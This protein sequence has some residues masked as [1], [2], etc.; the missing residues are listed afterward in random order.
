MK[1]VFLSLVFIFIF[2]FPFFVDALQVDKEISEL[3]SMDDSDY[4]M[5]GQKMD[6]GYVVVGQ[7]YSKLDNLQYYGKMDGFII[8]Y[9]N[10]WNMEWIN[11]FGGNDLEYFY[12]VYV[13][14]ENEY[15]VIGTTHSSNLSE[16]ASN[17]NSNGL[18]V[19]FDKNGNIL[20]N[21]F[22]EGNYSDSFESAVLTDDGGIIVVGHTYSDN[23]D[24]IENNFGDYR[25]LSFIIKYDKNGNI[26]WKNSYDGKSSIYFYDIVSL[27]DGGYLI[28]GTINENGVGSTNALLFKLDS[29]GN[30]TKK[31]TWGGDKFDS[32]S[33]IVM[34]D[35]KYYIL[36]KTSSSD[37]EGINF[38]GSTDGVVLKFDS[39]LNLIWNSSFGGSGYDICNDL[40]VFEDGNAIVACPVNSTDIAGLNHNGGSYDIVLLRYD[41][42]G[43]LLGFNSL[44][45][46]GE[47]YVNKIICEN[48][49]KCKIFG[50]TSSTEF[51]GISIKKA[52]SFVMSIDFNYN[53]VIPENINNGNINFSQ[54]EDLGIITASPN[55]G[56]MVDSVSVKD[57]NN[58]DVDVNK[59]EENK[60]NFVLYDDVNINVEFGINYDVKKKKTENGIVNFEKKSSTLGLIKPIPDKGYVVDKVIVKDTAGNEVSVISL[61]DGTFSVDL[62]T[63]VI[64]EVLFKENLE[65][66]K[67]GVISYIG[68]LF[69]V[70]IMGIFSFIL[71]M[72]RNN[73]FQL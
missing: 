37:I 64:V 24:W 12:N 20:W 56:Y 11:N 69:T 44:G 32:F 54:E 55:N 61:D 57:S 34:H 23:I 59:V 3:F 43:N 65:N 35:N 73:S 2:C 6:D 30:V 16:F 41:K 15:Y 19:K 51:E 39:D 4:F 10:S 58:N 1:K 13:T 53:V 22:L 38:K 50:Y 21:D 71:I 14:K 18:I 48:S 27:S 17:G 60:Y 8:K 7:S 66:P 42:D 47:D 46:N 67:T 9:D 45:G 49:S 52:D 40:Y 28:S 26:E 5:S 25:R 63:D 62:H 33:K 70:V 68:L 29:N 36:G 72:K 31:V